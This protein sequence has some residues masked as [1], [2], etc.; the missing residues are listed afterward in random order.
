MVSSLVWLKLSH[1]GWL[2]FFVWLSLVGLVGL[3]RFES[4]RQELF[5]FR[6]AFSF[7]FLGSV[8]ANSRFGADLS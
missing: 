1:L 4:I 5:S 7:G 2:A 6:F 8:G 3:V